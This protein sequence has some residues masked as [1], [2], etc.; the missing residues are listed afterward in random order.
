MTTG[1]SSEGPGK[2]TGMAGGTDH[3]DVLDDCRLMLSYAL[4]SGLGLPADLQ[5]DI[6]LLDGR[7]R[8]SGRRTVADLPDIADDPP[9]EPPAIP[10]PGAAEP[11]TSTGALALRIHGA[12]SALV[13]PATALSLSVTAPDEGAS[14]IFKRMPM[15]VRFAAVAAIASAAAFVFTAAMIASRAGT[16]SEIVAQPASAAARD[17]QGNAKPAPA[18]NPSSSGASNP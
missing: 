6:A 1:S 9:L 11:S 4:E 18:P 16:R 3:R 12:L 14:R 15:I 5:S 17:A 8:K 13:A 7:L 10:V 2:R